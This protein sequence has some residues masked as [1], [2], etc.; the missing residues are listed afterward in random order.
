MP[1]LI[2]RVSGDNLVPKTELQKVSFEPYIVFCKGDL[3]PRGRPNSIY[4]D[5]GF[6]VDLGP[7]EGDDLAEQISVAETFIDQHYSELKQI[8]GAD[9]I[10]FDFGYAPR[11]GCDGL[12]M[13]VQCDYFSPAF[14]LKCGELGVGIE[15]SLYLGLEEEGQQDGPPNDPQRGSFR[16]GKL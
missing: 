4:P 12:Q 16:G 5:S 13:M 10:R 2:L 7:D 14:L 15:V 9:D 8:C 6:S 3:M 1:S 11:R